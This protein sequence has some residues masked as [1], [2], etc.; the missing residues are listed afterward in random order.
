MGL[1]IVIPLLLY[2]S[3]LVCVLFDTP[4]LHLLTIFLSSN[5]YIIMY[6][7]ILKLIYWKTFSQLLFY[8]FPCALDLCFEVAPCITLSVM[9]LKVAYFSLRNLLKIRQVHR[10][11][12]LRNQNFHNSKESIPS[13]D[14]LI[15]FTKHGWK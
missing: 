14:L 15:V 9:L 7:V 5:C 12:I 4:F 1:C 11:T 6:I 3:I 8:L 10:E 2:L 13:P